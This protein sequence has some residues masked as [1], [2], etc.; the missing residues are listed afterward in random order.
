VEGC[1]QRITLLGVGH[2]RHELDADGVVHWLDEATG[3]SGGWRSSVGLWNGEPTE[4][5]SR[6]YDVAAR[7]T[8]QNEMIQ[9]KSDQ[10]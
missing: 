1:E 9:L 3:K 4:G 6:V 10:R 8:A 7:G 5:S 2:H